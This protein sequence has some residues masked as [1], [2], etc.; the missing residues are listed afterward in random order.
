[1]SFLKCTILKVKLRQIVNL[2]NANYVFKITF[3]L[4]AFVNILFGI[5]IPGNVMPKKLD[6]RECD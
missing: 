4:N 3:S 5:H 2:L 1:M 6:S